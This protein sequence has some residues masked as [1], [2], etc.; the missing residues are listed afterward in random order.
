MY[1]DPAFF[2][3]T[4]RIWFNS[5]NVTHCYNNCSIL[6]NNWRNCLGNMDGNLLMKNDSALNFFLVFVSNHKANPIACMYNICLDAIFQKT[7]LVDIE[8]SNVFR[9]SLVAFMQNAMILFPFDVSN[10]LSQHLIL[11]FRKSLIRITLGNLMETI[12]KLTMFTY[13]LIKLSRSNRYERINARMTPVC[14]LALA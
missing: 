7:K 1:G 6:C 10:P 8:F 11:H 3:T 4:N 9:C 2:Y 14:K 12:M 5:K 13:L